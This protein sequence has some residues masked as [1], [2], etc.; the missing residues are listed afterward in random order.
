M[1]FSFCFH[2]S[3][4][5]SS[6][7]RMLFWCNSCGSTSL[8][9]SGTPWLSCA[10]TIYIIYIYN[11]YIIIINM[12]VLSERIMDTEDFKCCVSKINWVPF[13][14]L[15]V[16]GRNLDWIEIC[17]GKLGFKLEGLISK[18]LF[19]WGFNMISASL[20]GKIPSLWNMYIY[21]Y[22]YCLAKCAIRLVGR[23]KWGI[24]G[25]GLIDVALIVVLKPFFCTVSKS[26]H[27]I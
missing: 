14:K 22:M 18:P 9:G 5:A 24:G 2:I 26:K 6:P 1:P 25:P 8:C 21:I 15:K 3:R 20:N 17:H 10:C 27:V 16:A 11:M 13:W 12:G 23:K 4:L 19:D 7:C